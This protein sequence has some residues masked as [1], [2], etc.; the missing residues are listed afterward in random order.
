MTCVK[1][2]YRVGAQLGLTQM[3]TIEIKV[4]NRM[5]GLGMYVFTLQKHVRPCTNKEVE[6][7]PTVGDNK[8]LV[9]VFLYIMRSSII[10]LM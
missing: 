7:L 9:I 6:V 2:F 10:V 1:S 8:S 3:I 4:P 5:V